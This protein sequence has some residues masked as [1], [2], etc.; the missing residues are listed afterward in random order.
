MW[1][2]RGRRTHLG[3]R[4]MFV[5]YFPTLEDGKKDTHAHIIPPPQPHILASSPS[6]LSPPLTSKIISFTLCTFKKDYTD[7][8]AV[9]QFDRSFSLFF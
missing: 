2:M 1:A 7:F 5:P 8:P 4:L 6:L 9:N 3:G